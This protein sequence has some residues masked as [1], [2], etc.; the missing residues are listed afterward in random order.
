MSR[1]QS[2]AIDP[3]KIIGVL[4]ADGW[5]NDIERFHV[6]AYEFV[7]DAEAG[8]VHHVIGPSGANQQ[9]FS[10]DQHGVTHTGPIA[11]ILLLKHEQQ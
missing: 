7:V 11:S 2:P 9:G 8:T 5:H 10:F 4:L 3:T 1:A 6:H